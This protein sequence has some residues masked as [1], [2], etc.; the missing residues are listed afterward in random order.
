MKKSINTFEEALILEMENL[1]CSEQ[2]LREGLTKLS[3]AI[4]SEKLHNMITAYSESSEDKRLQIDRI[5]S[6][7]C[8]EPKVCHTSVID[9]IIN[10][11]YARLKF[12]QD[13]KFQDLLLITCLQRINAYKICAYQTSVRYAEALEL[14]TPVALL[15]MIVS[16]EQKIRKEL[17]QAGSIELN[18][19][20][21]AVPA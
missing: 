19:K 11:A 12:A 2:K 1:Y 8:H 18:G 10:E 17:V 6:I 14:D 9:E 15:E 7:L 13:P 3:R 20:G 16:G 5:F 21:M 4:H